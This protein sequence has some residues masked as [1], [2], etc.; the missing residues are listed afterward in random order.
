[1]ERKYLKLRYTDLLG[2]L[3]TLTVKA[4][5]ELDGFKAFFDGSSVFGIASIEDGDLA[6]EPVPETLSPVPWDPGSYEAISRIVTP[7]GERFRRDPRYVAERVEEY[8]EGMGLKAVMG[9]EVEFFLFRSVR[10]H[11]SPA[12]QH[13]EIV[14]DESPW[15]GGIAPPVKTA[16]HI[17]EAS[18][19][20]E[21][22]RREV[23]EALEAQGYSVTKE[24]HEVAAGGQVEIAS[25]P[26]SPS[27]LGDFIQTLKLTSRKVAAMRGHTAVFL[28]KPLPDDNGSG[29]HVHVS[30]WRGGENVFGDGGLSDEGRHFIAGLIEHGRSL[31][32]IVS[33]TVNSYKR[34]VPGYEA[35]TLLAWGPRNRSVAVRVP[36]PNGYGMRVEYRPPDPSAN[37]YLALA[38]IIMAG[39]DG[40]RKGL[41]PPEPITTNAYKLSKAE[42]E[43]RGIRTLPGTL[44]E[45]LECLASDHDYL[46]PVFDEDIIQSFIDIKTE[47]Y[48]RVAYHPS[49]AEF[50][51]YAALL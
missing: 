35:P 41:E 40:V 51:Y 38:A 17:S 11:V 16:Y 28:P 26:Y 33:P 3:R 6:L 18:D 21:A 32:A 4:P 27:R 24:H 43:S 45:A 31:S 25:G 49:P 19:T 10:V 37:P 12:A 7:E 44:A 36:P 29:M 9:V 20:V 15:N 30:L 13:L 14:S 39:I 46:K 5:A 1:M 48:R 42:L 22:L 34:L 23:V 47:E 8:L 50:S 2:V